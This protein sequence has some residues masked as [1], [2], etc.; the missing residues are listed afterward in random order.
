LGCY[1]LVFCGLGVFI[2]AE[3]PRVRLELTRTSSSLSRNPR[4]SPP[5]GE[6]ATRPFISLLILLVRRFEAPKTLFPPFSWLRRWFPGSSF[7]ASQTLLVI[8]LKSTTGLP[9]CPPPHSPLKLMNQKDLSFHLPSS[10]ATSPWIYDSYYFLCMS[11]S[12]S[13]LSGWSL[14]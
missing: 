13:V 6:G 9:I 3:E 5:E 1:F 14:H 4:I 7:A 8:H 12:F 11:F 2:M 10:R